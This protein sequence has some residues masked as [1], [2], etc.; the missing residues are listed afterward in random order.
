MGCVY[1][2]GFYN[3]ETPIARDDKVIICH[4]E[5]HS[6]EAIRNFLYKR[7]IATL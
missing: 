4:C 1:N 7:V 2:D 5:E 6:D 3:I